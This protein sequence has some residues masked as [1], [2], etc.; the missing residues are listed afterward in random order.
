MQLLLA[1]GNQNKLREFRRMFPQNQILSP[2]DVGVRL[3]V[4]ETGKTFAQNAAIKAKALYALTGI[5]TIADDSGIVV[6][7][8]NGFP[9]VY[10]ARYA[11]EDVC[12]E[13]L[14][15]DMKGIPS[16]KRTARYVCSICFVLDE[17]HIYT[18]EGKCEGKIG[19]AEAGK[20]CFGYDPIFYVGKTS[21][22]Q[23]TDSEKDA[24][25]HR[26]AAFEK[27]QALFREWNLEI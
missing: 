7:A 12:C 9:G 19:F 15:R 24:I 27:L 4:E 6:D 1:T 11:S 13:K 20:N 18:V 2:K 25:S 21:M 17:A 22:A 5:P 16:E 8:L 3:D 14:L 26:G 23:M 10:S